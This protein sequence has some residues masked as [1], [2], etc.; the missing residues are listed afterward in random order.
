MGILLGS[1]GFLFLFITSALSLIFKLLKIEINNV[2][3]WADEIG[4]FLIVGVLLWILM[5]AMFYFM[6]GQTTGYYES[7]CF[8]F[9]IKIA[10]YGIWPALIIG[11]IIGLLKKD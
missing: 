3:K 10:F 9:P 11:G 7:R 4:D 2:L 5:G 6:S 8:I 1:L